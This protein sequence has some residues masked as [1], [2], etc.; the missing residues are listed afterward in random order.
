MSTRSRS[1]ASD[2]NETKP[3]L[4]GTST[5]YEDAIAPPNI[6]L[7]LPNLIGYIR[8]ILAIVSLYFMPWHPH[9]ATTLYTTSCL[10]DAVDGLAARALDQ[11]TK[12][13]AVLDMVTDRCATT[14]L[15]CYLASAYPEW[16]ILFQLLISLDISSH[17]M[18][19]YST[20]SQGSASHKALPST[21]NPLLR[22]YY[23]SRAVLF[24]I[25]F[26]NEACFVVLYMLRY[27]K[28]EWSFIVDRANIPLPLYHFPQPP[29]LQVST[30]ASIIFYTSLPICILK[31][32]LNLLQLAGACS[33]LARMDQAEWIEKER[34]RRKGAGGA[35]GVGKGGK[36]SDV[37]K[38]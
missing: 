19:M 3:L 18:H 36:G 9:Y 4:D 37:K 16:A 25:C 35:G 33:Q 5:A 11:S 17:Y 38:R 28:V 29:R 15:L 30:V 27:E 8:V 34:V 21:A 14:C 7:W 23:S 26:G 1:P 2:S 13:G 22:L 12:F 31:Q 6:Y 24:W 20:M 10:L 32:I